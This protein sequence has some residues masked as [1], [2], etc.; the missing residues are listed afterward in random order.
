MKI[1]VF[2]GDGMLGRELVAS[3][4]KRHE[5]HATFRSPEAALGGRDRYMCDVRDPDEAIE[6]VIYAVDPAAVVNAVGI[7]KQ[8]DDAKDVRACIEV[9]ALWPHRLAKMCDRTGA[10]LVH[11][12]TDCVFSGAR[13]NYTESAV[14]DPVDVYGRSKLLGEVDTIAITLRTSLIGLKTGC[15]HGLVE[16]FLSQRGQ[17]RGFRRAIFSGV[18]TRELA[19]VIERI[20]IEREDTRGVYHV[21]SSP[22]DKW[23]LLVKL[24]DRLRLPLEIA[25]DDDFACDR[26]LDASR[27]NAALPYTPPTWD[28]MLDELATQIEE[29]GHR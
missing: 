29:R 3:W 18:T 26:S 9:N 2:G 19:R 5:V 20:L 11:V 8:H 13:G 21:A 25:P 12:S 7:I 27:F 10:R 14:P 6:R 16:W 15:A 23:S 28:A 22:I 17:I 24:R 1:L 4:S